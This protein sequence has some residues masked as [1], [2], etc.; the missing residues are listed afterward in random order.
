MTRIGVS[1]TTTIVVAPS[2]NEPALGDAPLRSAHATPGR[3][4]IKAHPYGPS[5]APQTG[6]A[7]GDPV[8]LITLSGGLVAYAVT[9]RITPV[10]QAHATVRVVAPL[11]PFGASGGVLLDDDQATLLPRPLLS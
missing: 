5:E 2:Y 1:A 9:S 4:P 6:P 11:Y 10:Y 8:V 3:R 7:L